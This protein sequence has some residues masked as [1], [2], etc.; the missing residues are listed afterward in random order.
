MFLSV[1]SNEIYFYDSKKVLPIFAIYFCI[2]VF[3]GAA[4]SEYYSA[5]F[6][7]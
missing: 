1:D 5:E 6:A 7:N 4:I 3:D 2:A